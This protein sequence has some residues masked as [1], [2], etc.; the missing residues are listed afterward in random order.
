MQVKAFV[1]CVNLGVFFLG[2]WEA[3]RASGHEPSMHTSP[4]EIQGYAFTVVCA[5]CN[6]M[7][8][9]FLT[10]LLC[11]DEKADKADDMHP[12]CVL[13]CGLFVWTCVL[14]AGIF[15]HDIRTGPFQDVV[16]AQFCLALSSIGLACCL[17][18]VGVCVVAHEERVLAHEKKV[19]TE[20]V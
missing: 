9:V 16:V 3:E 13:Q 20:V 11:R 5:V 14:F 7:G 8:A 18:A 2:C 1:A 6:I 19:A 12:G 4:G 17:G 10:C 15:N